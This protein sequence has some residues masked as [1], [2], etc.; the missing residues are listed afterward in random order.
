M[1]WIQ[2]SSIFEEKYLQILLIIKLKWPILNQNMQTVKN[3]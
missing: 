3:S 1:F 2:M